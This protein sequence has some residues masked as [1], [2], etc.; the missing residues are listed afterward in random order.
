MKWMAARG[1]PWPAVMDRGINDLVLLLLDD[2]A[3]AKAK[4]TIGDEE[5]ARILRRGLGDTGV[6][7]IR[8]DVS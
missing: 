7:Q 2:E 3:K 6:D 8:A 4:K 5:E 1:D